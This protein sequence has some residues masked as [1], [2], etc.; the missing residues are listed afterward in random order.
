MPAMCLG[1]MLLAAMSKTYT[2][3]HKGMRLIFGVALFLGVAFGAGA[4][5]APLSDQD[6]QP[7]RRA[8]VEKFMSLMV[9]RQRVNSAMADK[10]VAIDAEM[11]RLLAPY[12]FETIGVAPHT[13]TVNK[14]SPEG[15]RIVAVDGAYVF[16][17]L[18]RKNIAGPTLIVFKTA[19]FSG[20]IYIE[21]ASVNLA[22]KGD[23][24][25]ITP[26]FCAAEQ[27]DARVED[28]VLPEIGR[29]VAAKI[30][31]ASS[32]EAR[33][34]GVPLVKK[35][36]MYA[37]NRNSQKDVE[38][39]SLFKKDILPILS[40]AY[41]DIYGVDQDFYEDIFIDRL[42]NHK[43]TEV[44]DSFV[45]VESGEG[46]YRRYLFRIVVEDGTTRI[47]PSGIDNYRR[48]ISPVWLKE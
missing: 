3:R 13:L 42:V 28:V 9:E 25:L 22:G 26:W 33:T 31:P 41:T 6:L 8:V 39:R 23:P 7:S 18:L 5:S 32:E 14:Y 4:V 34:E 10:I 27:V 43:I 38:R 16:V 29:K 20:D 24:S 45:V 48:T 37:T 46:P 21:P 17:K 11:T 47:M 30:K 36:M 40:K 15:F 1:E 35:L 2:R 12:Y 44:I 19:E